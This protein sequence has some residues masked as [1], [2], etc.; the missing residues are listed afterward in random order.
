MTIFGARR[1]RCQ[2]SIEAAAGDAERSRPEPDFAVLREISS[3]FSRRPRGE[4]LL[5]TIE[6]S[7]TTLAF[8][9]FVKAPLYARPESPNTGSWI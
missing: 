9:R 3:H 7:D 1:V 5:F 8:D 6:I 4:E 2:S